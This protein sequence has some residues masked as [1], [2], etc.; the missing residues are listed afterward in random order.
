MVFIPRRVRRLSANEQSDENPIRRLDELRDQAAWVLLGEPGAGKSLAFEEEARETD[1]L[2]I[3]IAKFLS[4]DPDPTW[5]GKT[6][7]LD[8]LDETRASGGDSSVLL[9]VRA[10]L[11][12]LGNPR[13][14]VACRA[15][16][17]FGS[18]DSQVV[19]DA[20]PDGQ[21]AVFTLEPLSDSEI[22]E[23]LRQNH[24]VPD[25][26][27]FVEEARERGIDGL[28]HNPQ[29]LRLLAEAI[30][31]GDWPNSRQETFELACKKLADEDS[32]PH[33]NQQRTQAISIEK[34]LESAGLLCAVLL[35]SDK[36]GLALDTANA[37]AHF[38][39]IDELL[40]SDLA[41]ARLAARR[42]LFRPSSEGEERMV[43]SHRSVAEYLAARWLAQQIDHRGLPLRRV[44]NL[45][46]GRDERTVAGLR[47]LYGWLA[48]HCQAARQRLIEADPVTV[49]VYGDAKPMSLADKRKLLAGLRQEAMQHLAFRWEIPSATP[50]GA[51]AEPDLAPE[52]EAALNSLERD[53][54]SQ[55][56]S[57]CVL[58][59]LNEGEPIPEL[60][61]TIKEAIVDDSRWSGIRRHALRVWL[62]LS[63]PNEEAIALLDSINDRRIADSDDDLAGNLLSSLYPD[64]I[65][66]DRLLRY[67]HAPKKRE[68]IGKHSMFWAYELARIA[69]DAHLPIL[70][71]QLAARTDLDVSDEIEFSFDFRRMLG[72]LLSRGLEVHGD[73][74]SDERLFAWLG[75]G[76]DKYGKIQREKEHQE[77]IANWLSKQPE[78]YK[79]V[80]ALC[81]KHCEGSEQV[82]SCIYEQEN[83]LHGATMPD[84]IGLWHL[85]KASETP[86][87]DLAESHLFEA[88]N[89]LM[90]QRGCVDLSLEKIEAWAVANPERKDWLQPLLFWEYPEW[91]QEDAVR[92]KAHQNKQAKQKQEKSSQAFKHMSA[93][94]EGS[95]APGILYELAGVW[96]NH[97]SDTRGETPAERFD[98]YCKNGGEVLKA[99][100]A[101]FFLCPLRD[102]LP[103]V[104]EIVDLSTQRREHYIRKPCLIGM[105]LRWQRGPSFVDTLSDDCLRRML[106]FRLTYGADNTPEWFTH[107]VQVRPALVAEVLVE[108][109]GATLKARQDFVYGIY[110]LAHDP[111]YRVVAE[112][113]VVPL[114][115]K[116]PVRSQST[117][118]S[119]LEYLLKAALRYSA[120]HL[121]GLIYKKLAAKGMDV[122]QKVY[123]LTTA[124]LL[125]PPQ[126][127]SVLWQ[128]IGKSWVRANHLCA[129]L[130]DRFHGISNDSALSPGTLGKLIELLSPHA[131]FERMSGIV[132]APMQRGESIRG[133]ITRLGT[134]ATDDEAAREIERLLELPS[135]SK[136][137]HALESARHQLRL[138]QRE[139]A[140]RFPPLASVARILSN[141]EP[142]NSA[143]LAAL[144]VDYLDQIADQ[145]RN[146]NDDGFRGFWN[147]ENKQPTGKREENLCRDSLLTRLRL[148]LTPLGVDCQPEGD[149]SNDKRAD[150]RLSYRNEFELPVE[151]KRDDNAKLWSALRKQLIGQY[152]VAPKAS[153]YGIYLVLWFGGTDQAAVKDGGKKP[154]SPTELQ[155][156]LE[157]QLN[158]EER[159]QVFVRVLD[160]SWPK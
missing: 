155:T 99:A 156:R 31:D 138:M 2:C 21:F 66:P 115:E 70:L 123:W 93:I 85:R 158:L 139:G 61:K 149:Y 7:F 37:D 42:K 68:Y 87:N 106:A 50:F 55:S 63:P 151:I 96:M 60:V 41:V 128:Y 5:Q 160:V 43:P 142:A 101:G 73:A 120:E 27:G 72:G 25:P 11:R 143:D 78:R 54:A 153:E 145:I 124:M 10:H 152:T 38:P 104:A 94:R 98:S 53:D 36:T 40:P 90:H 103:R 13:F 30:R 45:L 52:F 82:R 24:A 71:D 140:F 17:W 121:T 159:R 39:V 12:K 49:V 75:I 9:K 62:K 111:I 34:I 19:A 135:L 76:A 3:S 102:N 137:K 146:D 26:E 69:P 77:L 131:E 136:L 22:Q 88:V 33:R 108:Y 133:M 58:D 84:D 20:S 147:I 129:F 48:L 18:T 109:A 95:A 127:E 150:L 64:H 134:L 112:S 56:F 46:I 141:R 126:Y 65:A 114:L 44:T 113:A 116:F 105:E 91:R 117:Q 67:L 59:I 97:Y 8:G 89:T 100:E 80:L 74:I 32:R 15:A 47:G 157:A 125:N 130:D 81:Y 122:A 83:R 110:P 28:L 79:S 35:L 144:T 92:K 16:D 4:D 23:I 14:R 107:L 6:L 148:Y 29:T 57:D 51:L 154:T 132:T 86:N 119:Q 1:G 118:L